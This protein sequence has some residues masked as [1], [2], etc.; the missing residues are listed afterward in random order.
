MIVLLVD[1]AGF[2]GFSLHLV[3]PEEGVGDTP[4]RLAAAALLPQ[5]VRR[6]L[7]AGDP[8]PEEQ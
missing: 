5:D 6:L 7:Q 1:A 2:A 4:H 8:V 3:H